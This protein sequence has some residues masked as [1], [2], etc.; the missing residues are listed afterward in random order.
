ML[1]SLRVT[2]TL[3]DLAAA[4]EEFPIAVAAVLGTQVF[5]S[6][7]NRAMAKS[8]PLTAWDHYLRGISQLNHWGSGSLDVVI[9]EVRSAIAAGPDFGLAHAQLVTVLAIAGY[10][11]GS[12]MDTACRR[13][14]NQHINRAMQLDGENPEILSIIANA[15]AMLGEGDAGLRLA[16]RAVAL[17]PNSPSAHFALGRTLFAIGRTCDAIAALEKLER[18]APNEQRQSSAQLTIGVCL[19]FENR[20]AEA[21]VALDRSL[22][23]HS[24]FGSALWWKAVAEAQQGKEEEARASIKQFR[25]SE[26]GVQIDQPIPLVA[27]SLP[28]RKRAA[29]ACVI[30]R[31]LW[32]ETDSGP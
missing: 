22:A 15:H 26:S 29:E 28:L 13:E 31:R 23:Q 11:S 17:A 18:L 9:T 8:G 3:S 10:N 30:F 7:V 4:P 21:V 16:Q 25:Q 24:N 1:H 2:R 12:L 6:E 32:N 19:C 14:I 27:L 20:P 5:Q